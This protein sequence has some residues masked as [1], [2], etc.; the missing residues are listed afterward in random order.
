MKW[1]RGTQVV[2]LIVSAFLAVSCANMNKKDASRGIA[3][4]SEEAVMEDHFQALIHGQAPEQEMID[5]IDQLVNLLVLTNKDIGKFDKEL[6]SKLA[7]RKKNPA[8]AIEEPLASP[9]YMGLL[10]KW[11]LKDRYT[12]EIA[13]FYLRCLEMRTDK[14]VDAAEKQRIKKIQ[15]NT[16][17]YLANTQDLQRVELQELMGRLSDVF[18]AFVRAYKEQY[19]AEHNG[20][21]VDDKDDVTAP[22]TFKGAIFSTPD[23]LYTYIKNHRT[24]VFTDNSKAAKTR[25]EAFIK[26]IDADLG[27]IP[28]PNMTREV[29]SVQDLSCKDGKPLC[30]SAGDAGNIIGKAFPAGVWAFTFDDGPAKASAG[31]LDVLGAYSDKVN[32]RAKAT[33]FQLAKQA[34]SYPTAVK[35]MMD[36][37][38]SMANHSYSHADLASS[39]TNRKHE[40][41]E[42]NDVLTREYRKV[43][44]GYVIQ[45]FRCPYGSC[46][47]P[48]VPTARQMIADQ[49]QIHVYWRIDS[50]D[51]KLL[52]GAKVAALVEKQIQLLNHGVILMHDIHPTTADAMKQI[53]VWLKDQNNNKGANYKMVTIPEAVDM[54]NGVK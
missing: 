26:E 38:Y 21:P 19:A 54:V 31:M 2:A 17:T 37:G 25:R 43:Q 35:Q 47:A 34:P 46:Y 6:D 8:A 49:G 20:T 39:K 50:L 27:L 1:M 9:T 5:Y 28:D 14:N 33:F 30:A 53:L 7:V 13:Y 42:S 45:Y 41:V 32:P 18:Q 44:P 11:Q 51:W 4:A 40:I 22:E 15:Q 3:S 29:Q 23:A 24:S 36:S 48:K 12:N 16:A 10:K 52:N